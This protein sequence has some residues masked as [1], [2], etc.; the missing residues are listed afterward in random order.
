MQSSSIRVE[1]SILRAQK[2][3]LHAWAALLIV[4]GPKVAWQAD[5]GIGASSIIE[6]C[7]GGM[8]VNFMPIEFTTWIGISKRFAHA[9]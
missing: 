1:K 2:V 9:C 8:S 3:A 5:V 4:A 6:N 7:P